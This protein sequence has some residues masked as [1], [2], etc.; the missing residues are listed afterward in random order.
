[1]R[2]F[3]LLFSLVLLG[4]CCADHQPKMKASHVIFIGVDG[5]STPAFKDPALL[6]R[7]PNV[8]M[9]M[10]QG[11][12][13]LGKRSVM[14]SSSAINW[15][16][17]FN[18]L[19][20]EQHGYGHWNSSKPEIPAVLDNGRGMPPTVY[21]L[22]REQKP[23]A[24]A[25]CVYNW[26]GIGPLLDT[27]VI[28]YHL[29]DPG[30][31]NPDNYTMEKYTKERAVKYI[32]EKKPTLFTFYIGDVDEVGHR[33]G[34]DTP[35][36]YDCLEETDQSV[37]LIL[38]AAKDAGIFDDTIFVFSSDHGGSDKG[39]G[40]L[41]MLHLETPFVLY[42]KNIKKGYVLEYPMMQ[43]DLPAT[44]AYALGLRIPPEWRGRPMVEMFQ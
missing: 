12:F 34:W 40:Q 27:A 17:I 3:F 43:Y 20:T 16:T 13:T 29:Y 22:L 18:G 37:G 6:A 9:M 14:P 25:G 4:A 19:P 21:T 31:H 1:M 15:A 10:E 33:C 23:E 36:Y 24:E 11:A 26:D 42:G 44:L 5:V 8:K 7:M 35:E 39:H 28:D 32:L 41:Q 2:R 38:Q 30:Y